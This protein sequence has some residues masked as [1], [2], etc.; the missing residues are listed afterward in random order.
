MYAAII[1]SITGHMTKLK[2]PG[3][4]LNVID[5]TPFLVVPMNLRMAERMTG[6]GKRPACDGTF[7]G[8]LL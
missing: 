6:Y 5:F 1:A 3:H 8:D 4:P 2:L 7:F